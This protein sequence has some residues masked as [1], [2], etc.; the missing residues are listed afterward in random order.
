MQRLRL[1]NLSSLKHHCLAQRFIGIRKRRMP[2][3]GG[4]SSSSQSKSARELPAQAPAPAEQPPPKKRRQSPQN[5]ASGKSV[6]SR[7]VPAPS[8]SSDSDDCETGGGGGLLLGR[9]E[10]RDTWS[11]IGVAPWLT[12]QCTSMGLQVC[13]SVLLIHER[14]KPHF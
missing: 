8:S 6:S 1:L 4:S 5:D 13:E 9:A 7:H 11:S 2:R 12:T 10:S 3:S 14:C